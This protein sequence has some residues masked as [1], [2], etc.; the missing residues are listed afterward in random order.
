MKENAYRRL[1]RACIARDTAKLIVT[2]AVK[3]K[4]VKRKKKRATHL[5]A[6]L[7]FTKSVSAFA[8]VCMHTDQFSF[9]LTY[10]HHAHRAFS[11]AI[12]FKS[13]KNHRHSLTQAA[14]FATQTSTH[15]PTFK[16][17]ANPQIRAHNFIRKLENLFSF[18]IPL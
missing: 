17:H 3:S 15:I 6:R 5:V 7:A 10:T 13:T 12:H 4:C 1:R 8:N 16:A 18:S 2:L 11:I 9:R 14:T